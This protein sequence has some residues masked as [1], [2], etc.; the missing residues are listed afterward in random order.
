M[1]E[2]E[3]AKQRMVTGEVAAPDTF[4]FQDIVKAK[5]DPEK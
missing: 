3:E 1:K 5:M 4:C 2:A